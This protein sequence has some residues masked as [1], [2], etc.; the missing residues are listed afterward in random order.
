VGRYRKTSLPFCLSPLA[1]AQLRTNGVK[2]M[3]T[4]LESQIK[5]LK[6][7]DH[8]CAIYENPR[9]RLEVAV[10]F[11]IDG[12]AKGE[13]C[14]YILD[15]SGMGEIVQALTAA[16]VD[17]G[18]ERQRGALRFTTPE[19]TFLRTG[20]F[21]TEAMMDIFRQAEADVIA[22]GFTGVRITGEPPWS[23]L[24]PDPGDGAPQSIAR[25]D[26][27]PFMMKSDAYD[28]LETDGSRYGGFSQPLADAAFRRD[29]HSWGVRRS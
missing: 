27:K 25:Q 18:R 29:L 9:E 14:V 24:G 4:D 6:Q 23:A 16:G 12:L 19:E 20:K 13:R 7:G 22:D 1:F 8:I 10:P 3:A 28:S 21:E 2:I 5:R 26:H 11:V 15:E 17:V